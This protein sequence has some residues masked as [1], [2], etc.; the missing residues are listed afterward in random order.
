MRAIT[1]SGALIVLFGA[2]TLWGCGAREISPGEGPSDAGPGL[3]ADSARPTD[4]GSIVRPVDTGAALRL[5][6]GQRI[7]VGNGEAWTWVVVDRSY[8]V[9][10]AG[11]DV[12]REAF[13]GPVPS[14]MHVL[15]FP[16]SAR[17]KTFFQHATLALTP[18]PVIG[19]RPESGPFLELQFF[20]IDQHA[21]QAIDCRDPRLPLWAIPA[22]YEIA[23]PP[24]CV[25]QRG[26]FALPPASGDQRLDSA[27]MVYGGQLIGIHLAV[28]R[29][30]WQGDSP[31][32]LPLGIPER[33]ARLT[34]WPTDLSAS[35]DQTGQ[36]FRF[37]F[38]DLVPVRYGIDSRPGPPP[39]DAG[40]Q[41]LGPN[42]DGETKPRELTIQDIE[43]ILAGRLGL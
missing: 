27:L 3:A 10:E 16:P 30:T 7:R 12:S 28:D 37:A 4:Q 17:I 42:P 35:L 40:V 34:L 31:L 29:S 32:Q 5:L 43:A 15:D 11:L 23:E 41:D 22:P 25:N 2:W 39:P 36:I 33:L 21:R 14:A 20:S 18:R 24:A 13:E 8:T 9:V 19:N 6:E 26:Y 1:M 38:S